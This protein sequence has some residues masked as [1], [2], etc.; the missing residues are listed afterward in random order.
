[1]TRNWDIVN[2]NSKSNYSA[3]NEI[4]YDI[5]VLNSNPCDYND[6]YILVRSDII[7]I[8]DQAPFIICDYNDPYILVRGAIII[9]IG[10]QAPFI[11]CLTEIDETAID[12]AED[13]DSVMAIYNLIEYN[14]R[15]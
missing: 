3:G 9:I 8:G 10:D 13:L 4:T 7:T 5:E 11:K 1:M 15:I 6:P 2:D 12:D 14:N